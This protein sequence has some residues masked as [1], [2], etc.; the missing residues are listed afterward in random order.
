MRKVI[1][2][3]LNAITEQVRF[4]VVRLMSC[5]CAVLIRTFEEIGFAD[6]AKSAPLVPLYSEVG[7]SVTG[8][9]GLV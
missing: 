3:T 2:D 7:A 1:R 9:V 8:R 6:L 5:Y 4:Q